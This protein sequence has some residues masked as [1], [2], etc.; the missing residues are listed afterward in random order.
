MG[1]VVDAQQVIDRHVRVAL[2]GRERRVA[3]D[4]LDRAQIGAAVEH[5][6]GARVAQRVRVQ[7]GASG[8]EHAA[9]FR[10]RLYGARREPVAVHREKESAR[11]ADAPARTHDIVTHGEIRLDRARGFFSERHD[12]LLATLADDAHLALAQIHVAEIEPAELAHTK[13][14]AVH[15]LERRAVAQTDRF[16]VLG[17]L[18]D[19]RR[20]GRGDERRER[21]PHLRAREH[22]GRVEIDALFAARV[23]EERAHGRHV[24]RDA[25]RPVRARERP[26]PTAQAVDVDVAQLGRA[27]AL[28]GQ[29]L[30]QAPEIAAVA[31]HGVRRGAFLRAQMLEK[32]FDRALHARFLA[33]P[34]HAAKIVPILRTRA[35]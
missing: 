14:A 28:F 26:E 27:P 7:I 6:R 5:V 17:R 35:C 4:F 19:L 33:Q 31:R 18:D 25:A 29:E 2:G 15:Q 30:L 22:L 8:A 32:S 23:L 21:A 12:A 13:P 16:A 3:E 20:G 10:E 34:E 9:L 1:L 11:R 24:A